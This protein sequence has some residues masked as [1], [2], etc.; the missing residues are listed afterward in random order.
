MSIQVLGVPELSLTLS[1]AAVKGISLQY[2]WLGLLDTVVVL[3]A[4]TRQEAAATCLTSVAV[5]C[6]R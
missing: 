4:S 6:C 3:V 1:A 5:S 2:S